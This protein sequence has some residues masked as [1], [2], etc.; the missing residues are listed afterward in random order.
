M[1]SL[2][3]NLA[4]VTRKRSEQEPKEMST[5]QTYLTALRFCVFPILASAAAPSAQQPASALAASS[6]PQAHGAAAPHIAQL[7]SHAL[8]AAE[9]IGA[10][11]GLELRLGHTHEEDSVAQ[12]DT[13][14]LATPVLKRFRDLLLQRVNLFKLGPGKPGG[15]PKD[16]A[17]TNAGSRYEIFTALGALWG[18]LRDRLT[19]NFNPAL[20][21]DIKNLI[22]LIGAHVDKEL[23]N[24]LS[25]E[26]SDK[27]LYQAVEL[28]MSIVRMAIQASDAKSS[29]LSHPLINDQERLKH[30]LRPLTKTTTEIHGDDLDS[31][32]TDWLRVVFEVSKQ[33]HQTALAEVRRSCSDRSTFG[34]LKSTVDSLASDRCEGFG[35]NDFMSAEAYAG[36]KRAELVKLQ[37]LII[38]FLKRFPNASRAAKGAEAYCRKFR[39]PAPSPPHRLQPITPIP[40]DPNAFYRTLLEACLKHDIQSS[41]S[42]TLALSKLSKS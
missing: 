38:V 4:R 32:L 42:S 12:G 20:F 14:K 5:R 34:F 37:E 7:A 27:Y 30:I 23:P 35:P 18:L 15:N 40:S 22:F 2:S 10:H 25:A 31:S 21:S 26:D 6:H 39:L 11:L 29:V 13:I 33:D 3:R 16:V 1:S 19:E 8:S 36:W 9:N 24:N 17:F 41:T 28:F